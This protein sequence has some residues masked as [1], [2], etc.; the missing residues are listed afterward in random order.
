MRGEPEGEHGAL[1][2]GRL[3]GVFE[4]DA[5][6]GGHDAGSGVDGTD[7]VETGE[8]DND[9]GAK[10]R[11]LGADKTGIAALGDQANAVFIGPA[12][13]GLQRFDAGR[14]DDG[15]SGLVEA[16]A[17]LVEI[18]AHS[19]LVADD[20][21]AAHESGKRAGEF[22]GGKRHGKPRELA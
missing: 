2:F 1:G 12:D 13:H 7:A 11:H 17:G 6:F 9:L 4:D 18:S 3:V 15:G 10:E 8:A 16:L 5:G 21:V 14:G 22:G 20:G 19:A